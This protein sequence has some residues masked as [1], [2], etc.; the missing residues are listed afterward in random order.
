MITLIAENYICVIKQTLLAY[1]YTWI[2]KNVKKLNVVLN[3]KR[4]KK[5]II[6]DLNDNVLNENK[7]LCLYREQCHV[8]ND[9]QIF[10]F[11]IRPFC[12]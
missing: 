12:F 3:I 10:K 1:N 4:K 5:H 2:V 11:E 9:S 8:R 7:Q 6:M